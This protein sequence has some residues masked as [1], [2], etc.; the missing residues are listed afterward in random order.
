MGSKTVLIAAVV[1][2]AAA[3]QQTPPVEYYR[4]VPGF[5]AESFGSDGMARG[6]GF[7]AANPWGAYTAYLLATNAKGQRTWRIE[8]YLPNPS[9][10]TAQGST[11]YLFE[12]NARALLV[13]TANNTVDEPGKNDLKTV[14]RHLL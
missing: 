9:A 12:G 10:G 6:T 1:L 11:C 14:V 2:V 7:A 3:A 8:N 4:L 13:D 5:M